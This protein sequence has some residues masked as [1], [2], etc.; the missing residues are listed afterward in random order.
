M[1]TFLY[2][3]HPSKGVSTCGGA[4]REVCVQQGS[5]E[6]VC[7]SPAATG[8]IRPIWSTERFGPMLPWANGRGGLGGGR[9][10]G[11]GQ[12]GGRRSQ[13]LHLVP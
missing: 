8:L 6:C 1:V 12:Q 4:N 5:S 2:F 3:L 10:D 13:H 9:T 7:G 11:R